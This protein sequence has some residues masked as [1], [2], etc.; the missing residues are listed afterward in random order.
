MNNFKRILESVNE[1]SE[2]QK[3]YQAFF[4]KTLKKYDVDSSAELSDEKK[5]RFFDEIE[6]GWKG[7][8]E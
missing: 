8:G 6:S 7:E 3:E 1:K 4:K 2:K 5:K